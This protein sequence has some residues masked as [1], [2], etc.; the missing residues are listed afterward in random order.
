MITI[1][2]C[3]MIFHCI[4]YG[5]AQRDYSMHYAVS[6]VIESQKNIFFKSYLIEETI[7]FVNSN[8]FFPVMNNKQKIIVINFFVLSCIKLYV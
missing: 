2:N 8:P 7:G 4:I 5:L 1:S 6:T 3:L